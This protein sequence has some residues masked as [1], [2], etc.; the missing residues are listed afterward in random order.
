MPQYVVDESGSM[1]GEHAWLGAKS[2]VLLATVLLSV[3]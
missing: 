2:V 3:G 1:S